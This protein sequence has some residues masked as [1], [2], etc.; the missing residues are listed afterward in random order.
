MRFQ[1]Q[2]LRTC[3]WDEME[4][5]RRVEFTGD[6]RPA[7]LVGGSCMTQQGGNGRTTGTGE[8]L[9]PTCRAG[10]LVTGV[11]GAVRC[12]VEGRLGLYVVARSC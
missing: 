7:A 12:R 4:A 5:R 1:A 3:C 2:H 6:S 8:P 10:P 11:V 9:A